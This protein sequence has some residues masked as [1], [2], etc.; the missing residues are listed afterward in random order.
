MQ[1]TTR[2]EFLRMNL[3]AGAAGLAFGHPLLLQRQLLAAQEG[4]G[5]KRLIFIFQR[6]G[7]D[8]INTVI[9]RG[10]REY[11]RKNRPTL[12]IPEGDALDLGNG[13]AQAHPRLEPM[14]E[15][16][17]EAGQLAMIHRVGYADQSRSHFDSQNYWEHGVPGDAS[18][19]EGIFYRQLRRTLDLRD[20]KNDFVAASVSSSQ[21]LA[22]RG[23]TPF[24]SF[25]AARRFRLQGSEALARK[26]L[27]RLDEDGKPIPRGVLGLYGS[28]SGMRSS[29]G[30]YRDLVQRTGQT[31]GATL[32]KVQEASRVAYEPDGGAV[33]P[34]GDFGN[35]LQ[36]AAMLIKRTDV[37]I[38]GLNIG[39]WD[40]HADQGQ[41]NGAHGNLLGQ[42]AQ[43]FQALH[44]D[45][46][47]FWDDLVVVTMTEFGRTSKENGGKGTD[48][49]ESSAVF[50]AGGGV[51]GGV[52]NADTNTWKTGDLFSQKGR[53][54]AKKTDF[55]AVFAEILRQHFGDDDEVLEQVI[56]GY[57]E[58]AEGDPDGFRF[59]DFMI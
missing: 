35:K 32:Q 18:M 46:E 33:Y 45:L 58:A 53:Y 40:T 4:A 30:L 13:F 12:Y 28:D 27:G 24:P 52:Y 17:R 21:L 6:G 31:L 20:P 39:G 10:D 43:G 55:R 42:L 25:K 3:A 49:A 14:M 54:L 26:T 7:N 23:G 56:P 2:R 51:R 11:N 9:P 41:A 44:R 47:R 50:V 15:L 22:L 36:E 38:L 48:H 8:G 59:L 19:N 16:Y 5:N 37:R 1:P 34:G 57:G 29:D